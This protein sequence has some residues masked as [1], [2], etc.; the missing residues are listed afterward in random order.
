MTSSHPEGAPPIAAETEAEAASR[1]TRAGH[2][3]RRLTESAWLFP[4]I[5]ALALGVLWLTTLNLGRLGYE[6]ADRSARVS[7]E[8]LL[9]TYEAQVVRVLREIDQTLKALQYAYRLRGDGRQALADLRGRDLLPP[10]MVFA[11]S[12][13]DAEGEIVATTGQPS[14]P[15][16]VDPAF[17]ARVR[18]ADSL[19]EAPPVRSGDDWILGFGRRLV[20]RDG[21]FGGIVVVEVPAAFFVSGY[22]VAKLGEHGVLA[23]LGSDAVFRV[24]RSGHR[25]SFGGRT[26]YRE[27]VAAQHGFGDTEAVLAASPWDS[28]RRYTS[29]RELYDFP[30]AVVVGLA[31][32]EQLASATRRRNA[33]VSRAAAGSL[34]LVVVAGALGRMSW[35]LERLRRR[36]SETRLEHARRVEYLAFHDGLTGL[37]NRSFLYRLL[38]DRIRQADRSGGSFAVLFLDLDRFKEINDTFGHDAGDEL[39]REVARRLEAALRRSDTVARMGGDE[40][41]VLLSQVDGEEQAATAARKVLAALQELFVLLGERFTISASVGISLFPRDGAGEE[42]MLKNADIAMYEAKGAGKNTF[43]FFADGMNAASTERRHLESSL[44]QALGNQELELHYQAR[45][46][47]DTHQVTGVE[48]LLRWRHPELGTLVPPAFLSLADETGLILPIGRWVLRSACRQSVAWRREG[49][50]PLRM[51]VNLSPRQLFADDLASDVATALADSGLD[52]EMLELEVCESVLARDTGRALAVLQGLKDLGVRIT[53]DNF[54]TGYPPLSVLRRL[55][56]DTVKVDRLFLPE[57]GD[58]QAQEIAR[59]IVALGRTIGSS[60]VAHGVETKEQADFLR[61]QTGNEV[62]GFYFDDPLPAADFSARMQN[63]EAV[64]LRFAFRS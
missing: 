17:F 14:R 35:N 30:L 58:A 42:T 62:Q 6:S 56:V 60:V 26:D 46:D 28:V 33:N 16:A 48:A 51:A 38:A 27:V 2:G 44:R 21:A 53:V 19:T 8:E 12:V 40:F 31:E 39:L 3:L 55:A 41:V 37:P 20:G 18:L 4:L 7:S 15:G 63:E 32:E 5:A 9:E 57:P 34:L 11:V 49:L 45:R 24:R 59:A 64:A 54:G 36:E 47:L 29:A 25:V 22:E 43:R 10:E 1:S 13:A 52:P 61:Q 23:V 50:P